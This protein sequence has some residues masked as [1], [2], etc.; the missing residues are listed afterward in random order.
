M[1]DSLPQ[2][3]ALDPTRAGEA[4]AVLEEAFR[5]YPVMRH[6]V[7]AGEEGRSERLRALLEYFVAARLLKG[8]LVLAAEPEPGV[9]GA[10]ALVTVPGE[11]ESPPALAQRREE[12]WRLLGQAAR[13]RYD[14]CGTVWRRFTI[15]RPHHHLNL[16]GVGRGYAGR[17]LA[18]ALLEAIHRRSAADPGSAGVTLTTEDP[19]NLRLYERFGYRIIGESTLAP[20]LRTWS[21]FRPD[22]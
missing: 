9:V 12:L 20:G 11:R 22:P 15:D 2:V 19:A 8:G 21:F 16:I 1:N 14:A 13:A 6:V 3:A 4:V 18:R 17:G 7:G 10:V 5:D